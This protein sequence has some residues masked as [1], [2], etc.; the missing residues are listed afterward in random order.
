MITNPGFLQRQTRNP[1][2][3]FLLTPK[4]L[5]IHIRKTSQKNK[6][7]TDL[8]DWTVTLGPEEPM[9]P[10]KAYPMT[11]LWESWQE[12][13]KEKHES[14]ELQYLDVQWCHS[15]SQ[16]PIVGVVLQL[17]LEFSEKENPSVNH[18]SLTKPWLHQQWPKYLFLQTLKHGDPHTQ[19]TAG[20][21]CIW[22]RNLCQTSNSKSRRLLA[23]CRKTAKW[24]LLCYTTSICH[25]SL[26][27]LFK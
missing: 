6:I 13:E 17:L 16:E 12:L 18:L 14:E 8:W 1:Y 5:G 26:S 4:P 19:L 22:Q 24:L 20:W 3:S 23:H 11:Q 25:N 7:K 2:P 27:A 15:L 21:K 10:T 9:A